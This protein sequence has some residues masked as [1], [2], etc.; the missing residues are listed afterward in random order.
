MVEAESVTIRLTDGRSIVLRDVAWFD[1]K[2]VL[3]IRETTDD[4]ILDPLH[5]PQP[6]HRTYERD[7]TGDKWALTATGLGAMEGDNA[8][9]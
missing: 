5:I 6:V 8:N 2:V 9:T 3:G 7:P 4:W 1:V